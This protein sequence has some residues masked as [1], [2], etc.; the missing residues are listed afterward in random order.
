MTTTGV[1]WA[2]AEELAGLA[3]VETAADGVFAQVGIVFPAGTT[4]IEEVD[5]PS[6][7]LVAG[8]PPVGFALLG[9][10]DGQVHLDQLAV[11]P[12]HGRRGVGG[13]LLEAVCDHAAAVGSAAVTLTTFR[14]VLWN[15]PWY[16]ERGFTV[17]TPAEWGPEMAEL[18]RHERE[19]GIELA[20]RVV[21]R[22]RL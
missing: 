15:G 1:R 16:A 6:R 2:E 14:D 3:A 13:R 22:R 7:V 8:V 12:G 17:L 9:R 11:H 18:V 10:V 19:L 4:M 5:D 20:P 21:M